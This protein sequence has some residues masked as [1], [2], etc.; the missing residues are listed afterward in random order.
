MVHSGS[1][2]SSA[3]ACLGIDFGGT[4]IAFR[5]VAGH[6]AAV[7]TYCLWPVPGSLE[8]DVAAFDASLRDLRARCPAPI[9]S[10]VV[11]MPGTVSR[12]GQ[13]SAWPN[14]PGWVGFDLGQFLVS[15]FSQAR[16]RWAD[17]GQIAALAEA[18]QAGCANLAYIGVGTGIGG[19]LV[20]RGKPCPS[21]DSGCELGHLVIDRRGP[22]CRCGRRGCLQAL[23]SGPATLSRASELCG[24]P[25]S[26]AEFLDAWAAGQR[27]ALDAG[28]ESAAAL[29]VAVIILTELLGPKLIRIG[30]GFA[31]EYTGFVAAVAAEA[32]ALDRPA[33][34]HAQIE[35]AAFGGLSSLAGAL[36]LATE[37]SLASAPGRPA[38]SAKA[39]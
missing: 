7:D 8:S 21:L 14:R 17:D 32:A 24:K 27:W 37:P 22:V 33:H 31:R 30:G 26:P 10:V 1:S 23:A 29:A 5:A 2:N 16:V 3:G 13:I 39:R 34:Q 20:L 38:P 25:V 9:V 4:K 18:R 36:L 11:A 35:A 15:R 28:Q 19:G 12:G 6:G